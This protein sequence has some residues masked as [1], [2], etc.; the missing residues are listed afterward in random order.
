[1][2]DIPDWQVLCPATF[3]FLI[4][5]PQALGLLFLSMMTTLCNLVGMLE[6]QR[7]AQVSW[8]PDVYLFPDILG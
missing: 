8:V 6:L 4:I 5:S 3:F 1:M 2:L 7:I